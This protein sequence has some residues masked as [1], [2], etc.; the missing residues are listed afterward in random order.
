MQAGERALVALLDQFADE[1]GGPD[2]GNPL[3]ALDGPDPKLERELGLARAKRSGDQNFLAALDVL[4]G[5]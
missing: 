2:E 5:G 4:A 3:V 1:I